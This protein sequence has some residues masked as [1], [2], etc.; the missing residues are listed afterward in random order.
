MNNPFQKKP[1]A[2]LYGL[3]ILLFIL[4]PV[5]LRSDLAHSAPDLSRRAAG[6]EHVHYF[7]IALGLPPKIL[8]PA[9]TFFRGCT[10]AS[11]GGYGCPGDELPLKSIYMDDYIIDRTLKTNRQYAACVADGGLY[12][13]HQQYFHDTRR[14]L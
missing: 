12:A 3:L 10:P 1:G 7:P 8:I 4:L 13:A 2:S 11:N 9:G 5:V 6:E 14:L